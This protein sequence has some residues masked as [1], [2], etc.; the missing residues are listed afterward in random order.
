[1]ITGVYYASLLHRLSK[2]IKKKRSHLKKK[3]I[4]FHQDKAQVHTCT[5]SISKI[6][7]LKFK[8]LQHPSYS[9]DLVPSDFF[10][11]SNLK[12]WLQQFT[13]NEEII[14]KTDAYREDLPKSYFLDGLK[15]L[16]KCLKKRVELKGYYV[17]K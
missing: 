16:E 4:L 2:E 10:L 9:K 3:K 11:F 12:K 13:S 7:E 6:M 17:E 1:M 8:L 15:K 5:V 14:A